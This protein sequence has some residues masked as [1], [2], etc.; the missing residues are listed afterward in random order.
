MPTT[1][2]SLA[3]GTAPGQMLVVYDAAPGWPS[4]QSPVLLSRL[5][6]T[7]ATAAE[8]AQGYAFRQLFVG[9]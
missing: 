5:A 9:A 2:E 3:V 7:P 1:W 6:G 8:P 4:A